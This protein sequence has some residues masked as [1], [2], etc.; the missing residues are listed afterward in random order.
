M[1]RLLS[2]MYATFGIGSRAKQFG[3]D[4][5]RVEEAFNAIRDKRITLPIYATSASVNREVEKQSDMMLTGVMQ[6]HHQMIGQMLQASTNQFTDPQMKQYLHDA[7]EAANALMKSVFRHFN[8]DEVDRYVPDVAPPQPPSPPP[9]PMMG[10]SG[11]GAPQ[12]GG[13]PPQGAPPA[14]PQ[15]GGLLA[16]MG[17][18]GPQGGGQPQ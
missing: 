9:G 15:L 1:G 11:G 13:A 8:Y 16:A 7:I 14:S 10:A 18:Q 12:S 3:L 6:K 2:Q 17:G 5:A 4:G